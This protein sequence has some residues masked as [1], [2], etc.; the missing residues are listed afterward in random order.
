[1]CLIYKGVFFLHFQVMKSFTTWLSDKQNETR[2]IEEIDEVTLN[3]YIGNYLLC[4]MKK[5]GNHYEPDTLTFHH[6]GIER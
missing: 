3:N 2:N 4:F 1:M 5:D 6:R